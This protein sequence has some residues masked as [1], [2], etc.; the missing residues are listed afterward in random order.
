[1]LL[2]DGEPV[3]I[4]SERLGHADVSITLNV[5]AHVLKTHQEGAAN[6]IG[7]LLHGLG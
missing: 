6:R 7:A 3:H 5:Y 4:V 2:A 1:L